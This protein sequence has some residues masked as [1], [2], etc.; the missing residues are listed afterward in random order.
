MILAE[1]PKR[2][3]YSFTI[4]P[5]NGVMTDV[6]WALAPGDGGTEL[7]L[8]HRGLPAGAEAFNLTL[9]LDKGWDEHLGKMRNLPD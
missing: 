5:L 9:V 8:I 3:H 2:S 6:E 7:S 1:P 4:K